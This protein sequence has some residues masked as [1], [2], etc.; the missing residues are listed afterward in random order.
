MTAFASWCREYN[1]WQRSPRV[2]RSFHHDI[3][4]LP[5]PVPWLHVIWTPSW[6]L[7]WCTPSG[8]CTMDLNFS[9]RECRNLWHLALARFMANALARFIANALDEFQKRFQTRTL[10]LLFMEMAIFGVCALWPRHRMRP[11]FDSRLSLLT[12]QF[13]LLRVSFLR[14][15]DCVDHSRVCLCWL[16]FFSVYTKLQIV[17]IL[18]FCSLQ[19]CWAPGRILRSANSFNVHLWENI[20]WSSSPIRE[21][22]TSLTRTQ[23]SPRSLQ[24]SCTT[25]A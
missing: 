13:G 1:S 8:I 4:D 24:I 19:V 17:L 16:S 12:Q 23:P 18:S 22:I 20:L 6:S 9:G 7:H 2:C 11:R 21:Y 15:A 25:L 14:L 5:W 3:L 10:Q